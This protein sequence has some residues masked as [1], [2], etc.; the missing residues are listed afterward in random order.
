MNQILRIPQ[1]PDV[2]S[3]DQYHFDDACAALMDRVLE[4]GRPD[5][6][7]GIRTGGMYVAE[8][9]ARSD[10][11]RM[12]V[13]SMTCRR[14][15]TSY[16]QG[17]ATLKTLVTSLPRPV[18]DRLRVWEH[19]M[20]TSRPRS[21][22]LP[23]HQFDPEE[24]AELDH[25]MATSGRAPSLVVV[26]D[27]VDSGATLFRVLEAVLHRAAPPTYIRSAVITVTTQRP[28]ISPDYSLYHGQLCRF[29][30]SL[31]A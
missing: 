14:P 12:P 22:P 16:K 3:F 27:A 11:G 13:L 8:A 26:D 20:L 28:L 31:D 1:S 7:I 2:V 10:G 29:P 19:A 24:L 17:I 21:A 9:M 5:A 23:G 4:G 15:T 30:W 25:W 6:L 18:V